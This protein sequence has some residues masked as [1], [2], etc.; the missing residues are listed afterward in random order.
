MKKVAY[1]VSIKYA[2]GLHKEFILM[3]RKLKEQGIEVRYLLSRHY[4]WMHKEPLN[5]TCFVTNSSNWLTMVMDS[6]GFFLWRWIKLLFLLKKFF[7]P[8]LRKKLY[9]SPYALDPLKF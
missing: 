7:L 3:G 4:R 2:I 6:V 8:D 9:V 1:I 5:E